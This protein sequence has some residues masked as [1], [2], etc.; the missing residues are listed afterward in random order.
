MTCLT[1]IYHDVRRLGQHYV[2][3][4]GLMLLIK[5]KLYTKY[6]ET[7]QKGAIAN[8]VEYQYTHFI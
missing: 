4:V 2:F 7:W 3:M 8:T 6:P 5:F 1:T